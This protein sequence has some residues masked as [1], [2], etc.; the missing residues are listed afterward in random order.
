M[1][2]HDC[3]QHQAGVDAAKPKGIRQV[4]DLH[5]TAF[6]GDDVQVAGR[7]EVLQVCRA[8]KRS[9]LERHGANRQL[10]CSSGS[11]RMA[12]ESFVPLTATRSAWLPRPIRTALHSVA[13]L[14]TVDE[15]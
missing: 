9:T 7:I 5:L 13:S 14:S 10:D 2:R 12:M 6:R 4:L 1:S 8:G 11:Q 15:P 3:R